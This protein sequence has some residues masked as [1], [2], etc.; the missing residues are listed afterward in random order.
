[1]Q[2][3]IG[4][5]F[6]K[7]VNTAV[8]EA[9]KGMSSPHMILFFANYDMLKDVTDQ[10]KALYP[11]VPTIGSCAI[12]Y[13]E[14]DASDKKLIVIA[15]GKD[16]VVKVGVLR[17]LSTA[18]LYDIIGLKDAVKAVAP[19]DSD[20]ICLELCTNDEERLVTTMNVALGE[21]GVT[22]VGGTVFGVPDGKKAYVAVDGQLY[23]DACCYA[24]IKNTSGKIRTYSENIYRLKENAKRHIATKVNMKNKELV[25]MDYKPASDVYANELGIP[26][27]QIVD[28]VLENPLGRIIGDEVYI[29][30]Q[31][32]IG[33]GGSLINYKRFNEND[34]VSILQLQDYVSI[35]EETRNKIKAENPKISFVFS[36][37]CIY[38]HLLFDQKNHLSRF[39][40]DMGTLGPHVGI[41]G[42][43]EQYRTQHVNQTMV[44]AVFD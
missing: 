6:S 23:E 31:Y 44:C 26:K 40:D 11:D 17:Y 9:T 25:Q 35:N 34:T 12:S 33:D 39:M 29:C 15:F 19:G 27:S 24:V 20:T 21:K 2:T 10:L 7:D 1:M 22:L 30:S 3:F 43:G 13:F 37:N 41:V 38:R 28:N 4:S 18:P 32:G 42:G 16:A 36:V 8:T 5:S 14:K